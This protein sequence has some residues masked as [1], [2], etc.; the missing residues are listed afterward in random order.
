MYQ[1]HQKE[2]AIVLS[3]MGLPLL[4]GQDVFRKIREIN[5]EAKIILASGYFDPSLRSE[6]YK[7]GLMDFIQKPYLQDEVLQKI[8]EAIDAPS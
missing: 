2:I 1:L 6:M 4:S 8:R 3:D 5:P 7:A